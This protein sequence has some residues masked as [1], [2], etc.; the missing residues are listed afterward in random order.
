MRRG[1]P[2]GKPPLRPMTDDEINKL[3]DF[4]KVHFPE[5]ADH[6]QQ[7][8][9]DDPQEFR[10]ALRRMWPRLMIMKET[11]D[12][13]PQLGNLMIEDHKLEQQI[14]GKVRDYRQQRD[15]NN[16]QKIGDE[17]RQLLGQQFDIRL[18]RRRLELADL[19]KRLQEQSQRLD[20]WAAKK[21]ENIQRQFDRLTGEGDLDW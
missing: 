18:Q 13:D 16:K 20:T 14:H 2:E 9:K 6:L 3:I 15:P 21:Q 8:R 11:F 4:A 12:R 19:Q 5:V 7:L 10:R 1:G 17:L